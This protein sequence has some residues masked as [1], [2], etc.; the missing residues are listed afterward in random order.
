[1]EFANTYL[2]NFIPD[3]RNKSVHSVSPLDLRLH[4]SVLWITRS[5][6]PL[7]CDGLGPSL[8]SS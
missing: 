3:H 7:A 5:L 6:E 2:G 1:M 4:S 8:L